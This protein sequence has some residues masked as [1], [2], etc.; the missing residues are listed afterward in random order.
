MLYNFIVYRGNDLPLRLRAV[1]LGIDLTAPGSGGPPSPALT[2]LTAF[3]SDTG[4]LE[5][6]APVNGLRIPLSESV[7]I[8]GDYIG[9]FDASLLTPGLV[10]YDF[11]PLFLCFKCGHGFK[12]FTVLVL[13]AQSDV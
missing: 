6:A 9:C 13:P 2:D 1:D 12:A 3:F 5:T 8:P 4:V 10:S 7:Y 11:K